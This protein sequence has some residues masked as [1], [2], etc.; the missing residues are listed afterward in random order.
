M[1]TNILVYTMH[2]NKYVS[3]HLR[4][5]ITINYFILTSLLIFSSN[6]SIIVIADLCMFPMIRLTYPCLSF[7]LHFSPCNTENIWTWHPVLRVTWIRSSSIV[8]FDHISTWNGLGHLNL[9]ILDSLQILGETSF[10]MPLDAI[11][12]AKCIFRITN[13]WVLSILFTL[14]PTLGMRSNFFS[15]PL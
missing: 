14:I 10:P 15:F 4:I 1:K 2:G 7:L 8:K 6:S 11:V 5:V 12:K 13:R 9:S 3:W